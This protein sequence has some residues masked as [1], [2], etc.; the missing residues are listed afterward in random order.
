MNSVGGFA[1][2]TT[3]ANGWSVI[4][5]TGSTTLNYYHYNA[6]AQPTTTSDTTVSVAPPNLNFFVTARNNLGNADLNDTS[7]QISAAM[8]GGGVSLS[9]SNLIATRINNFMHDNSGTNVW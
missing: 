2:T 3:N 9:T 1:E 8:I 4:T 5:R 6:S 7:D